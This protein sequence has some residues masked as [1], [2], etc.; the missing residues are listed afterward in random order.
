MRFY[1]FNLF[2][3]VVFMLGFFPAMKRQPS[4]PRGLKIRHFLV[5]LAVVTLTAP[6]FYTV[7]YSVTHP[8]LAF[9]HFYGANGFVPAWLVFSLRVAGVVFGA[10]ICTQASMLGRRLPKARPVFLRLWPFMV[11]IWLIES[12][13]NPQEMK[14]RSI[15]F[16]V[17]AFYAILAIIIWGVV[18]RLVYLHFRSASSDVLFPQP[19]KSLQATATAPSVLTGT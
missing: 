10:V 14:A 11:I 19:N 5:T 4:V 13:P 2:I 18:G 7:F 9:A 3:V 1:L 17:L 16:G 8:Q 12:F 6:A 15:S